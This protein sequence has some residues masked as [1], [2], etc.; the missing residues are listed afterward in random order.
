MPSL[1]PIYSFL[2]DGSWT[3]FVM[4]HTTSELPLEDFAALYALAV[5][6]GP[7]ALAHARQ[8]LYPNWQAL[9]SPAL[10]RVSVFEVARSVWHSLTLALL[11]L[12][13]PFVYSHIQSKCGDARAPIQS[14]QVLSHAHLTMLILLQVRHV[15]HCAAT[16]PGL[17]RE[18]KQRPIHSG[19][20]LRQRCAGG[21]AFP[22]WTIGPGLSR[23][24]GG[25]CG[26]IR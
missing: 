21:S 23:Q 1:T 13:H 12:I 24:R 20:C 17:G 8:S 7:S 26:S 16:L 19:R 9:A 11:F 15:F 4:D 22:A 3:F 25:N 2:R 18:R 6:G 10:D 5:V 14:C